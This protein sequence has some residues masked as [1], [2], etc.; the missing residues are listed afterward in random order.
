MKTDIKNIKCE[1][2]EELKYLLAFYDID[3]MPIYYDDVFV[4]YVTND[5]QY[6]RGE[7][8]Y[9]E[10]DKTAIR[11]AI[12][13]IKDYIS[14]VFKFRSDDIISLIVVRYSDYKPVR[15]ETF[16]GTY[17]KIFE[18]V[19]YANDHLRYCNGSY[20]KFKDETNEKLSKLWYLSI[21]KSRSMDIYYG[22]GTVD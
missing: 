20:Y 3:K 8:R 9:F 10:C 7:C 15:E 18:Q 2:E 12:L 22:N 14:T 16:T 13:Q 19:E 1:N 4:G 17:D 21:S 11:Y 5:L 6:K